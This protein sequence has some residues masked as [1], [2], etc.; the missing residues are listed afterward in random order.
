MPVCSCEHTNYRD[1]FHSSEYQLLNKPDGRQPSAFMQQLQRERK[2]AEAKY[3][4]ER[5]MENFEEPNEIWLGFNL[6]FSTIIPGLFDS[7]LGRKDSRECIWQLPEV[8][9]RR[10]PRKIHQK[11]CLMELDLFVLIRRFLHLLVK[12]RV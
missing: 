10:P 11:I 12:I 3:L 7:D 4:A 8:L 2:V 6:Y 5:K 9:R 1:T